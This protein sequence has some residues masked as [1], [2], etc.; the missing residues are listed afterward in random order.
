M[1]AAIVEKN[2]HAL[3]FLE[4]IKRNEITPYD[5]LELEKDQQFWELNNEI[6]DS[7]ETFKKVIIEME[8]SEYKWEKNCLAGTW[9]YTL[10]EVFLCINEL[11]EDQLIDLVVF[12]DRRSGKSLQEYLTPK[13]IKIMIQSLN[14]ILDYSELGT[15]SILISNIFETFFKLIFCTDALFLPH[16]DGRLLE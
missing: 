11:P 13:N 5:K 1:F 9:K 3:E 14:E 15:N 7:L 10:R 6:F 12:F 8:N 2:I 16:I 4:V